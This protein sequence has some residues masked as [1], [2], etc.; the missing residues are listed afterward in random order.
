[1]NCRKVLFMAA[2]GLLA[3]RGFAQVPEDALRASWYKISGTARNQAIGGAGGSLGGDISSAFINPAGIGMYKTN[4]L[5]LSPGFGFYN[6]DAKFRGSGNTVSGSGFMLG[7]SGVV[8][9]MPDRYRANKSAA[10][11][12]GV[13]RLA[14]FKNHISYS[15]QNNF[16][17]FSESYAAEIAGSG[18]SLDDALNSS[19]ISFP[20]RMAL[21]TYLVDTLTIP[22]SGTE[23]VGTPMR[24]ALLNDTAFMLRQRNDIET[25]GGIT[26]IALS[27]GG[28]SND[29]FYWGFTFGLP[30]YNY[31][32]N[33]TFTESDESG[34]QKNYFN[35]ASLQERYHARGIGMNLKMGMIYKP[36]T[37]VRLG[38]ALHTPTLYGIRESYDAVMHTDL[39]NYNAPASVTVSDLNNGYSPMYR[40]DMVTPWRFLFSG[41]YMLNAVE[42]T[43]QQRGFI[44]ADLEYVTYG[45][46]RFHNSDEDSYDSQD[47]F[48]AV[49]NTIKNIYKGA[50]NARVGAELKFNTLMARA[51]FAY[52]GNPYR[53]NALDAQRMYVSGGVGY[54]NRGFFV[55]LAYVH[56]ITSDSDFPYRL[57]DKANTFATINQTGGTV[58]ATFG[59]K[60]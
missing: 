45:S 55:D 40:Y 43:R 23:V 14:D 41:S 25:S 42:D 15:G 8:F 35:T 17:S 9:G 56:R 12:I 16:S 2:L 21:Y 47:Y 31:E 1:M 49:N 27:Y 6:N 10:F 57:S 18:L 13:N 4:E 5:V 30:I 44:T 20:G 11:A 58:M 39:E 60:F 54:R 32:R 53:D 48:S 37:S 3:S 36:V 29:R 7:T 50:L 59:F 26:E 33:S 24:Y 19:S 22:G 52:Y 28:N 46:N 38:L 34:N 51:G